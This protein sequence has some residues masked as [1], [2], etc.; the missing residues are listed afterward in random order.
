[1][2]KEKLLY[3]LPEYNDQLDGHIYYLANFI[4]EIA[5]ELDVFVIIE[6][7]KSTNIW[8]KNITWY[9]AQKSKNIIWRSLGILGMV[10]WKRLQG[11]KKAYIHYSYIWAIFSSII[12][13]LTWWKTRYRN[14]GMM[15][16]FSDNKALNLK[17]SLK[18]VNYLVTWVNALK[19]WYSTHYGISEKKIKIMP[20]RIELD[21]VEK[22]K[23]DLNIEE[24]RKKLWFWPND[25][26][27]LF[28]HRL[29]PRKWIHYICPIAKELQKEKNIKFLI[30]GD[31]PYKEKFLEEINENKLENIKYIGR[32]ANKEVYKYFLLADV[33]LMPSEEEWFP[34]VLL[35]SMA[36]NTPYVASDIGGVKEISPEFQQKYIYDIGNIDWFSTWIIDIL[37]EKFNFNEYI[38]KFNIEEVKKYFLKFINNK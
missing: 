14:C 9:H 4:Q 8:L 5:K 21:R 19:K 3:I 25:R 12:M 11:Y 23:K 35:E 29:A 32:V 34:R 10:F 15:R 30:I 26:I 7:N 18:L 13:R 16:L 38:N 17:L 28:V 22:V 24:E 33:F 36:C 37:K 27:V 20:N 2:K 31:G 6:K 1:M